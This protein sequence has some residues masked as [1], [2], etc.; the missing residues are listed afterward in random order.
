M[1]KY[2]SPLVPY[3]VNTSFSYL[4]KE[5]RVGY[6]DHG[7]MRLSVLHYRFKQTYGGT[8][9][10]NSSGYLFNE[11]NE[12]AI[13]NVRAGDTLAIQGSSVTLSKQ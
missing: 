2:T 4:T 10:F 12:A 5:V 8:A 7:T 9:N 13:A 6:E 11:L 1:L 3:L